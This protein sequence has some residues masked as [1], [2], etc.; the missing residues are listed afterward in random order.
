MVLFFGVSLLP[1]VFFSREMEGGRGRTFIFRFFRFFLG[2]K[3]QLVGTV[4]LFEREDF[5]KINERIVDWTPF[6]VILEG[7]NNNGG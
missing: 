5:K 4:R 3:P 7:V 6:P 2:G 1:E